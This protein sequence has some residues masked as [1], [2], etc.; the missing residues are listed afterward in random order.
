MNFDVEAVQ[1]DGSCVF[2]GTILSAQPVDIETATL[3]AE[4]CFNNGL[5]D[6]NGLLNL[7]SADLETYGELRDYI[8]QGAMSRVF[9]A[10]ETGVLEIVYGCADELALNYEPNTTQPTDTCEY[11]EGCTN[12]GATNFDATAIIDD[13]S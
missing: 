2:D 4:N 1:D 6:V 7:F 5:M 9:F 8:M 13:G 3:I 11:A 10:S 12:A